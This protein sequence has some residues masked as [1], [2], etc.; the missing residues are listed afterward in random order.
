VTH[1]GR[2]AG[3]FVRPQA[4]ELGR[5]VPVGDAVGG[6]QPGQVVERTGSGVLGRTADGQLV[7]PGV[8]L[9][10][11]GDEAR[12]AHPVVLHAFEERAFRTADGYDRRAGLVGH[13][14]QDRRDPEPVGRP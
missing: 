8:Q 10:H 2:A 7:Q 14:A 5:E 3:P 12:G 11:E 13:V 6:Q 4:L 1:D 9:A